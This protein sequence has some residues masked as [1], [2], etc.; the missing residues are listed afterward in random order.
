[1]LFR[2][3]H[4]LLWK[5]WFDLRVPLL[6][7]KWKADLFLSTDGFC[8]L[9][10]SVPQCMVIHDLAYLHFPGFNKRSHRYFF[11]RYTGRFIRKTETIA[12]VSNFSSN[13]ILGHFPQAKDK[14]NI[15]PSPE[16]SLPYFCLCQLRGFLPLFLLC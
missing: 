11:Q 15:V 7:K 9:T 10:T 8:S 3:R 13:D 6:I 4:P 2:S 14:L 16:G 12:T 1:M 5:L